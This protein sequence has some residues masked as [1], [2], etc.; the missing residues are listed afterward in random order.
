[1]METADSRQG[2]RLARFGPDWL[3]RPASWRCLLQS[4][5]G[6]VCLMVGDVFPQQPPERLVGQRDHGIEY[7]T[8]SAADPAFRDSVLPRAASPAAKGLHAAGLQKLQNIA[9]QLGVPVEPDVAVGT[10]KRK[11]LTYLLHHPLAAGTLRYLEVE[12]TR[13]NRL[14]GSELCLAKIKHEQLGLRSH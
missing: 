12:D 9:A 4:D 11:S 8:A 10:R 6:S 3:N 5:V 1:M 7:F 14:G 2:Q 13:S